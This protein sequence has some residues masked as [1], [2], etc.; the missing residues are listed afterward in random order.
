MKRFWKRKIS[1]QIEP[2][3][4]R[5]YDLILPG[6]LGIEKVILLDYTVDSYGRRSLTFE[7]EGKWT[8]RRRLPRFDE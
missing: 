2:V 5:T 7:E 4:G 1:N 8:E 3:V 6:S